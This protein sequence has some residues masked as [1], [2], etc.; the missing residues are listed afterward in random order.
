MLIA[1]SLPF[2]VIDCSSLFT[3][4]SFKNISI[5]QI[6][7]SLS[8]LQWNVRLL[9]FSFNF[10]LIIIVSCLITWNFP[11]CASCVLN[12][13]IFYFLC[14][15]D[16]VLLVLNALLDLVLEQRSM[17]ALKFIPQSPWGVRHQKMFWKLMNCNW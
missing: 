3:N 10:S 16:A 4:T 2:T 12:R 9:F 7:P 15:D 14:S 1:L 5:D 6:L 13:L 17:F 8:L 11:P